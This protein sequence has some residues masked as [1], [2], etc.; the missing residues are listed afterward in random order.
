M[1]SSRAISF[2]VYEQSSI[3]LNYGSPNLWKHRDDLRRTN[4]G[5]DY[6]SNVG[7]LV[8][9]AGMDFMFL[10]DVLAIDDSFPQSAKMSLR[11][12]GGIPAHDPVAIASAVL[13]STSKVGVIVTMSS[14]YEHP[15]RV[16]RT[17]STLDHLSGG[18]VGLNVVTSYLPSA[19]RNFGLQEAFGHDERYELADEF[20]DVLYK[21]WEGSWEEDAFVMDADSGLF[22]E[23]EKVHRIDHVGKRFRVAGPHVSPPSQQR[24]P[25]LVVA[26]WSPR[27]HVFSANHAE[28]VFAGSQSAQE[29]IRGRKAIEAELNALGTNRPVRVYGGFSVVTA[30]SKDELSQKLGLLREVHQSDGEAL[31]A[32]HGAWSGIDLLGLPDN[33]SVDGARGH[34]ESVSTALARDPSTATVGGLKRKLLELG[35]SDPNVFIGLP[36]EV[37]DQIEEY[38]RCSGVDGLVLR[39]FLS[40][41]SLRDFAQLVAPILDARGLMD[42]SR[43]GTAS[44][45]RR[46]MGHDLLDQRHRGKLFGPRTS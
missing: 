45:R 2:G 3:G 37:T 29:I 13:S 19:A 40:P 8:E 35:G 34:T 36:E 16:A 42:K 26:G 9:E 10:G 41:G 23:P 28:V 46:L 6:W 32:N 4:L 1:A 33:A 44:L 14:T 12:G 15:F 30:P 20:M 18:R 11:S 5:Y 31:W 43:S 17:F 27:G 22:A 7:K 25:L 39:T 24:T 21:L 38:A